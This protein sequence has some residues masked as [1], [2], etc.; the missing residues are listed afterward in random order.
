MY[1]TSTVP[2]IDG[3]CPV[4]AQLEVAA[5]EILRRA[6]DGLV[7]DVHDGRIV[8]GGGIV[9]AQTHSLVLPVQRQGHAHPVCGVGGA[10]LQAQ[11]VALLR[12]HVL[13]QTAAQ[14]KRI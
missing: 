5:G 11:V 13:G 10:L 3:E 2:V 4:D 6:A 9:G 1:I 14:R 7:V 12:V 8:D